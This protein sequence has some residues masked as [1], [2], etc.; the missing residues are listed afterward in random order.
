MAVL[1][2]G[3]RKRSNRPAL[4]G[5]KLYRTN[6]TVLE[7]LAEYFC[8]RTNDIAELLRG[9]TP[10]ANDKRSVRQTL[11]VL[12]KAGVVARLPYR[13]LDR[14]SVGVHYAWG[15][16]EKGVEFCKALW[17]LAKTFDEHSQRTLDHELEISFFHIALKRFC[18][19]NKLKL[20]WQQSE[21]LL[22]KTAIL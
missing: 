12:L 6:R 3:S 20:Y 22:S 21:P 7:L 14:V 4:Q 2:P 9:R 17:P 13:D 8:L 16:S 5:L 19:K 10:N 1:T 18:E 11:T 15:L